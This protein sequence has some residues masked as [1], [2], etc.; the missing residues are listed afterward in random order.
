VCLDVSYLKRKYTIADV[1]EEITAPIITLPLYAQTVGNFFAQIDILVYTLP[2][3]SVIF[4]VI[5][6]PLYQFYE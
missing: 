4:H 6:L 1:S 3:F 2:K 5:D